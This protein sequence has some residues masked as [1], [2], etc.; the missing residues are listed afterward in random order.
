MEWFA[1]MKKAFSNENEWIK[2]FQRVELQEDLEFEHVKKWVN[3]IIVSNF[4][5]VHVYL[6][7]QKWRDYFQKN[8]WRNS[9]WREKAEEIKST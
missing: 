6:T 3:K 7:M 1:E 4:K 9:L 8:G 5:E 2:T